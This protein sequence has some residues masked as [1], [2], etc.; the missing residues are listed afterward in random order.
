MTAKVLDFPKDMEE[1]FKRYNDVSLLQCKA[2]N[3]SGMADTDFPWLDNEDVN[4]MHVCA[5][6]GADQHD[7]CEY[8]AP[9]DNILINEH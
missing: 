8:E 9:R 4:G 3:H 2:C 7:I 5:S 1:T 6:C